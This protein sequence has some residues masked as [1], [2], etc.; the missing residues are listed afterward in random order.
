MALARVSTSVAEKVAAPV[1]KL[2][3]DWGEKTV[4]G[5]AGKKVAHLD[6]KTADWL[7]CSSADWSDRY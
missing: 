5:S 7:G 2:A 6:V 3:V 1:E 4:A